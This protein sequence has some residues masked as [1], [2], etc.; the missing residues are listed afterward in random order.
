MVELAREGTVLSEIEPEHRYR[1]RGITAPIFDADGRVTAGLS[2]TGL[3]EIAG[4][5]V[6][7]HAYALSAAAVRVSHRAPLVRTSD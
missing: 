5:R 2:L 1:L 7:D 6:R 3:P 4:A